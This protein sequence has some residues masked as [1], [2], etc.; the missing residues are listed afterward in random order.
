M[1]G[2]NVKSLSLIWIDPAIQ[3][4]FLKKKVFC[5]MLANKIARKLT[6]FFKS[7]TV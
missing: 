1:K 5:L 3:E 4:N 2:S 7:C 6:L